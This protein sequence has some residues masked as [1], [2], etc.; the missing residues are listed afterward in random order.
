MAN[1][2]AAPRSLM[3]HEIAKLDPNLLRERLAKVTQERTQLTPFEYQLEAAVA[4]CLGWDVVMIA[5]T[6]RGKTLCMV[7]PC[8]LSDQYISVIIS[9]LNALKEDQV[10]PLLLATDCSR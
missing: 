4:T 1:T 8:F 10:S 9:P 5:G 6:G 7:M 2:N 3:P